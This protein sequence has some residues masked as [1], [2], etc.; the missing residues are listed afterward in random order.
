MCNVQGE[1]PSYSAGGGLIHEIVEQ[2]I[3]QALAPDA[4][5]SQ[6][7]RAHGQASAAEG[8]VTGHLRTIDRQ[9]SGDDILSGYGTTQHLYLGSIMTINWVDRNVAS[10][11]S[12]PRR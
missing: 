8:H 11:T 10:A 6:L 4:L 5:Q 1:V 12:R 9:R 2:S 3:L 7:G